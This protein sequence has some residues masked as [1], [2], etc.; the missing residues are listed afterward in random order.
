MKLHYKEAL[1]SNNLTESD[2]I[3]STKKE[4]NELGQLIEGYNSLEEK[5]SQEKDED[6][7]NS[8]Q[9]QSD[10]IKDAIETY[11][12]KICK[13]IE[14]NSF[15]Q[16]QAIKLKEG[17]EKS[18]SNKAVAQQTPKT[19]TQIPQS[20]SEQKEAV[21]VVPNQ[22]TNNAE[23]V[24]VTNVEG[25]KPKDET[26]EEKKEGFGFGTILLGAAALLAAAFGI[27]RLINR[28]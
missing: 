5:I 10:K 26:K 7:L 17:R 28:E 12:T 15:Y 4:I 22:Q 3:V 11:D 20:Q 13:K 6:I 2:L 21:V 1:K 24:N 19:E 16:Q 8:L 18:K 23:Q 14:K 25:E 9:Q 27:D